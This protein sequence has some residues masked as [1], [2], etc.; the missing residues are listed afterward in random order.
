M[1]TLYVIKPAEKMPTGKLMD[2]IP[3]AMLFFDVLH[4]SEIAT[5][6]MS[7]TPPTPKP[8]INRKKTS[9]VQEEE[10]ADK[11]VKAPMQKMAA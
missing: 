11:S 5:A 4:A 1:T 6:V 2:K 7:K 10:K 8:V 3:S 9:Q